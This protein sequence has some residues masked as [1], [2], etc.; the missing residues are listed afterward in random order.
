VRVVFFGTPEFAVPSLDA[1]LGE[2]FDV[3]AVVTQPDKPQG[4]SRST[5]VPPP[6]KTAAEAEDVPVLQ[7]PRPSDPAFLERLRALAPDV[8]V[9][10]AYGHI[11][12]PDLLAL[13]SS[14]A[15]RRTFAGPT[16]RSGSHGWS[17]RS[18]PGPERGPSST[19]VRSS[20][21]APASWRTAA[22]LEKYGRRWTDYALRRDS[23]RCR[24]RKS[25]PRAR[26]AW[27]PRSGSAGAARRR[28]SASGEVPPGPAAAARHHRRAD[29]PP[30]GPGH[31]G[32]A[33]R[34][35]RWRASRLPRPRARA[36]GTG[37]LRT[38]R[39]TVRL[40]AR[41]PI[42]ERPPRR[43]A[44]GRRGGCPT[45]T[46]EPPARGR[47]PLERRLV[48]RQ[49]GARLARGGGRARGRCRLSFGGA[50]V[51]DRHPSRPSAVG[52]R[53]AEGNRWPRVAGRRH[54]RGDAGA[55]SGADGRGGYPRC[56]RDQGAVA[57]GR[58]GGRR[59]ADAPGAERMNDMV[60]VTVNGEVRAV[61][62]GATLLE[63]L[64]SLALDPRAVVVEHNRTIVRRPR[65]AAVTV[66]PG[67]AI[68]L[69]HFVGGG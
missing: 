40:S 34:G 43:R 65:L 46:G 63:L 10:V 11:L 38:R 3:V 19:A 54:R 42:R 64:E 1:L 37:P 15:R 21:S 62:R 49:V 59:A 69:V 66:A 9:V 16:R 33:A 22:P 60:D 45:G 44:R 32:A 57:R 36:L 39:P 28:A 35:W 2:G 17:A 53:A 14:R 26:R 4:R 23:G 58:S 50:G 30:A 68:E 67:D 5:A 29:R 55:D 24:W 12:R 27:L 7:P 47:A 6:V 56:R 13:P 52:L 8:G 20:C 48:D 41:P 25:S 18:T 61:A 31:S 51:P